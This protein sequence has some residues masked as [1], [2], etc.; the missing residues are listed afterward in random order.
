MEILNEIG[1]SQELFDK[2][3]E[4]NQDREVEEY[5]KNLATCDKNITPKPVLD[6]ATVKEII[7]FHEQVYNELSQSFPDPSD[8]DMMSAGIDD[9]IFFKFNVEFEEVAAHYF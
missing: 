5:I 4:I 1:V 9:E 3:I 2:S 6:E 7:A 8:N